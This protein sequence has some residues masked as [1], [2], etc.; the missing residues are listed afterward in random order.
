[1]DRVVEYRKSRLGD[2]GINTVWG[3]IICP[4]EPGIRKSGKMR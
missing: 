4:A 1:M 2:D 3:D